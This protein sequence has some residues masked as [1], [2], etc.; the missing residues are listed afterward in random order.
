[1]KYIANKECN[2]LKNMHLW[3]RHSRASHE[4]WKAGQEIS[5]QVV[6]Q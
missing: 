1:M 4:C 5:V 6:I 2:Y 3:R